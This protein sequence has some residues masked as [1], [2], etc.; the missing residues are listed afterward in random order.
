MPR[1]R[2]KILSNYEKTKVKKMRESLAEQN[3]SRFDAMNDSNLLKVL[4]IDTSGKVYVSL[5]YHDDLLR[6]IGD[7]VT[8]LIK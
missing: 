3:I 5:E 8:D 2:P 7:S 6:R 4:Y 1:G